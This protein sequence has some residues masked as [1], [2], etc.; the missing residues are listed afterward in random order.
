LT[1]SSDTISIAELIVECLARHGV[2][3]MFSQSLPS[4]VLLAAEDHDIRQFMYRTENAGT[5]MADGYARVSGKVGVVSAQNGPAATLLVP[6]LAEALKVS[7]P[8]VAIVQD[9]VRTQTDRNAFQEFDH[10]ALFQSCTKWARRVTEPSRVVDYVDMAFAVAASG[11]PGPVALVLPAD[12]LLE[13]IPRPT[14]RRARLG[15]YPLDRSVADPARVREAVEWLRNAKSPLLVAGGGVHLSDACAQVAALQE[16]AHI[17]VTTTVMGKGAV[18]ERHPL[19]IGVTGYAMGPLSPTHHMRDIMADADVILLVGTRTN[20]NGTDSW[21]LYPDTARYIHVDVDGGEIGRN[22]E[23]LRLAGD[24]RLTLAAILDGLAGTRERDNAVERRI[25]A[26]RQAH[27]KAIAPLA[28]SDAVPIRP[29]RLIADTVNV[30]TPETIVVADASY[31]T[32]WTACYLPSLRTGMRF[33]TP[34][35][36]AG[37]GWGLPLAIGAKVAQPASPVLCM[38][39]DGGFA[40]VWS[41]LETAARRQ[42]PVVVTVLNN[43]CLAYQ[44]DAEDVK[45]GRHSTA[46]YFTPVDHAAIARACGCRGV[47]VEDPADYL[48]ALRAALAAPET[49]VID[50]ITDPAAYPPIT[51]FASLEGVRSARAKH[52]G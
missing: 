2:D 49:T 41:E 25:A 15:Y 45:F 40:H 28:A 21:A 13:K 34:R 17:P 11:R 14:H 50:V 44:K 38:V 18:D 23:A 52:A 37:L 4:A 16:E 26:G 31:A 29:E 3:V 46:C 22:Y 10:L 6:G 43:G 20:Q 30:L 27:A 48:P 1:A 39:G 7:V 47:R 36:L 35:G 5:A 9:V 32:L 51:F 24:A 12:L 19:S 33:I 8:L 42:T